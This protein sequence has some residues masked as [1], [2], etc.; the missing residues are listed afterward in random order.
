MLKSTLL[1]LLVVCLIS[2][3]KTP[4]KEEP[5]PST[6][7]IPGHWLILYPK[8][9][10]KTT[11]QREV[12]ASAQDSLVSLFGLK[13]I[14]FGTNG[15]FL[16][17]DS[18]FSTPGKWMVKE[19]NQVMVKQGG[20]GFEGFKGE[21]LEIRNDTL[22]IA[23]QLKLEDETIQVVWY[24]KR[25]DDKS[26]KTF[27]GE[28]QNWW[29]KKPA[30]VED[31]AA[32][33]KR[34]KAIL[35]Y[36]SVYFRLVSKES[37]YFSQTKVPLPFKYYQHA[38]GIRKLSSDMSFCQLF[39]DEANAQQA[40]TILSKTMKDIEHERFPSGRDFVIEYAHYMKKL[41]DKM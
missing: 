41:A 35:E 1:L 6:G 2:S 4:P 3:C 28:Q 7:D 21:F 25:L 12:Y 36:Y 15:D 34:L 11:E 13:L 29:R 22:R 27:F 10:L 40:H 20:K 18:S 31:E 5:V 23:E 9:V 39:Y 33:K 32:L 16:Q 17:V 37:A 38:M 30:A 26:V 19:N 14:G 8:H 24:L